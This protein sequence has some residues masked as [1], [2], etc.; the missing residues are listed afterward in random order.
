MHSAIRGVLIVVPIGGE[1]AWRRK[2]QFPRAIKPR[3]GM[4]KFSKASGS[5]F[6]GFI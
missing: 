6:D 4:T 5:G 1:C 3:F 2:K